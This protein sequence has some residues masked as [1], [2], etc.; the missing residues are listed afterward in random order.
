MVQV[1]V[2]GR[3]FLIKRDEVVNVPI[4]VV[5]VLQNA[6]ESRFNPKTGESR[7]VMSYPF[8]YA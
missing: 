3:V 8:Q 5:H 2:N 4:S 7:E 1:A 6:K